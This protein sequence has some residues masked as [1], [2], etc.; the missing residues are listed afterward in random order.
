MR[1]K[2]LMKPPAHPWS[3]SV[4]Q[5]AWYTR[6]PPWARAARCG[7]ASWARTTRCRRAPPPPTSCAPTPRM[8]SSLW[9][10][11][12]VLYRG[13]DSVVYTGATVGEGGALRHCLVGPH[14]A[15]PPRAAAA[16]QVRADTFG[17]TP[18]NL[19]QAAAFVPVVDTRKVSPLAI[20]S[21]AITIRTEE[22]TKA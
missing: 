3:S 4:V 2:H 13:T 5:T 10:S 6:A 17:D 18:S 12:C 1:L 14:H 15:V 21:W 9:G 7:T 20:Y 11:A 16:Q 8:T 19:E 22:D